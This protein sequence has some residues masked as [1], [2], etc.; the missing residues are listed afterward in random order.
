VRSK[1]LEM[2]RSNGYRALNDVEKMLGWEGPIRM[3]DNRIAQQLGVTKDQLRYMLFRNDLQKRVKERRLDEK[4]AR[5]I[6][7]TTYTSSKLKFAIS[8]PANW[9]VT[10]DTL[11]AEERDI[12]PEQFQTMMQKA[13]LDSGLSLYDTGRKID[14]LEAKK[15]ILLK[16]PIRSCWIK[17]ELKP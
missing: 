14:D 15:E 13:L 8:F 9:K 1:A 16:K 5:N 4:E 6:A 3:P 12:S 2:L 10:A 7:F 11:W 17:N